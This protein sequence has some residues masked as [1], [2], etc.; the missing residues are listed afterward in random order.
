[1]SSLESLFRM[2]TAADYIFRFVDMMFATLDYSYCRMISWT[3]LI[4]QFTYLRRNFVFLGCEK[5]LV[6]LM[7]VCFG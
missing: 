3:K 1:M 7:E 2:G 6:G 5:L 4:E